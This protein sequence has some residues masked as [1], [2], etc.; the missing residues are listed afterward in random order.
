MWNNLIGQ[1]KI[2]DKFKTICNSGRVS[3]AYLFYGMDG[4]GKDAAAIEFAKMINCTNLREGELCNEC[5]NCK[6]ISAFREDYFH[7]ICALPTGKSEQTDS[8]PLEYLSAGDYES[9]VEQIKIKATNPYHHINIPGANNIRINSIRDLINKIHLTVPG[10]GGRFKKIFLIS[11]ADKMKQEAANALLKVLEEPPKN[12]II[13][14][15]TSKPYLLPQTITGRCQKIYFEPLSPEQIEESLHHV[16]ENGNN[17]SGYDKAEIK[18]ASKFSGGSYTRAYE[19]LS[20]GVKELR[21]RMLNFLVA[22]IKNDYA[23]IAGICREMAAKNN[24]DRTKY[25]LF[26]L[27][28]W[29]KDLMRV[30]YSET[31]NIANIDIKERLTKFSKNYPEIDLFNI[32][33]SIEEAGKLMIQNVQVLLILIDLSFK[34]RTFLR[35]I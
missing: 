11:E 33:C 18:L 3:H 17:A 6:N 35:L 30:K 24:K 9:Y 29:F 15:T 20:Y 32:I 34:L 28:I 31:E 21:E 1:E 25:F 27:Y 4:V 16:L 26:H 7:F 23:E 12:S 8:S 22:I 2:K 13:I 19:M 10:H 5:N 14:M